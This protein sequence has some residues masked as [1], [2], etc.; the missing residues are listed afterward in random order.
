MTSQE[1]QMLNDLVRKINGTQLQEKDD[2]A[3]RLLAD[4]LGR[5]PDAMYMLAQTVLVQNIALD[6]AKQQLM[7]LQ[8]QQAAPQPAK[9]TSF[10]GSLLGHRDP[11]PPPPPQFQG[12]GQYQQVPPQYA[13]PQYAQPQYAQPP[14]PAA[15]AGQPSFL[16]S[17]ATTAAGVAAGALAFEGVESLIHGGLGG[18]EGFGGGGFGGGYGG[19]FGGGAPREEII[20]NYYGSPE[21]GSGG[22][23][24]AG[25]NEQPQGPFDG[26]GVDEQPQGGFDDTSYDSGND[27]SDFGNDESS[28]V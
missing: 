7:Q 27:N 8:Q 11:A 20:N 17:A 19:D 9:A 25:P 13:Q 28:F 1:S 23:Y 4:G 12:Q 5:N 26:G 21:G 15:P 24:E 18:H 14:F 10:L 22:G 3:E 16:R 2:D 6:Q